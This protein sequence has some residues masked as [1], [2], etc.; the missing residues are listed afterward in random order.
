LSLLIVEGIT[1]SFGALMAVNNVSLS[2]EQGRIQG[3]IG[4]NGSGKTTLFNLITKFLRPD[5]GTTSFFG[6]RIDH[7]EP[8]QMTRLGICRTF[9]ITQVFPEMTVLENVM[10]GLHC[11]QKSGYFQN[12]LGVPAARREFSDSKDKAMTYLSLVGLDVHPETQAKYLSY[13]QQKVLEIARAL[14]SEPKLLL[15]DEPAAGLNS[16]EKDALAETIRKLQQKKITILLIEHDMRLV[17][18][19]ADSVSVLNFGSKI[20]EGRPDDV[21]RNAEVIEAYL[22]KPQ[23]ARGHS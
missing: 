6:N 16:Q 9:Q 22:G 14:A 12:A 23:D 3:L 18:G 13:G 4:P 17:M 5:R 2:V 7:L 11:R 21:Q 10:A 19:L 8:H 15:L 1:K 20:A